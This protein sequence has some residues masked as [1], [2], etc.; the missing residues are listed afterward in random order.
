MAY[1]KALEIAKLLNDNSFKPSFCF[2]ISEKM[3]SVSVEIKFLGII[4]ANVK[5]LRLRC[6][7]LSEMIANM[8]MDGIK[9]IIAPEE[10]DKLVKLANLFK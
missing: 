1:K 3:K 4:R 2:E 5:D 6:L 9:Q 10:D 8:A 7:L